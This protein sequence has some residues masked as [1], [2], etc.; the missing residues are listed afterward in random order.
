MRNQPST[1]DIYTSTIA[2]IRSGKALDDYDLGYYKATAKFEPFDEAGK[3]A[4]CIAVEDVKSNTPARS[5]AELEAVIAQ[6]LGQEPKK[7]G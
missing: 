6:K 5:K 7:E 4:A 2:K 1:Y 3:L